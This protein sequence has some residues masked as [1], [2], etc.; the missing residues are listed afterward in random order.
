MSFILGKKL[1]MTQIW[2][3]D[4]V[5]PVTLIQALPNKVSLIKNKERDGYEAVQVALG[6]K[7]REF[8]DKQ[9]SFA[10][11]MEGEQ[12]T[13]D[14]VQYKAGDM[15]DVSVFSEGDLVKISGLSKGRGFQGVVKRHGFAGGP[16]THGQKNRLR[17][18]GSIG[19]TAPQRVY[20]GRRMAG[21]MGNERVSIKNLL[22]AGVDKEKNM[23]MVRGAVPGARGGLLEISK[24]KSQN[25]K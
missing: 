19:S 24:I 1:N 14:K 21:R 13:N 4:A 17:A 2:K 3:G 11:A 16:K 20:P 9:P 15:I 7:K 23:L 25:A 6:K 22:I 5:V 18:P 8:R 10:K 12:A